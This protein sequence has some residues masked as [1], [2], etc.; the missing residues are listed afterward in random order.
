MAFLR[1][2]WERPCRRRHPAKFRPAEEVADDAELQ[3]RAPALWRTIQ[4]APVA[5]PIRATLER[6]LAFWLFERFQALTAEEIWSMLNM[7]VSIEET[8]AYHSPFA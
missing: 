6:I 4:D 3:R 7:L 1:D 2:G 8:D 5:P